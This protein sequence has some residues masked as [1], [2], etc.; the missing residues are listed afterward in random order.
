MKSVEFDEYH[1]MTAGE[2]ARALFEDEKDPRSKQ[3][4]RVLN[5]PKIRWWLAIL[6]V[7]FPVLTEAALI[8][9]L[10][11]FGVRT[12]WIVVFS[13]LFP[14]LYLCATAKPALIGAVRIYQRTAPDAVR[15]KCRYEPSCSEY[16]ILCLR[17]YGFFRGLA[18][19][20][21]R[22]KRCNTD[23]GGFDFP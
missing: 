11:H 6:Y 10:K 23:G 3:Y 2:L 14:V 7:L 18:K 4:K 19:G 22:L 1:P 15:N 9:L 12:G 17:K 16:M 8:L 20:I 5:R 13:I 21:G